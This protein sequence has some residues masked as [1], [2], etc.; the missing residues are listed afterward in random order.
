[1]IAHEY[2]LQGREGSFYNNAASQKQRLET[3]QLPPQESF[4]YWGRPG[5]ETNDQGDA[6]TCNDT[7]KEAIADRNCKTL[8]DTWV[9]MQAK[10]A[11][12]ME[13]YT[14]TGNTPN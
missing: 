14:A 5:N 10:K 13:N 11:H 7:S 9:G 12:S 6:H 1:M 3:R 4:F 8:A 2:A